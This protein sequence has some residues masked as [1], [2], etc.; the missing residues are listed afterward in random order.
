MATRS[1][2]QIEMMRFQEGRGNRPGGEECSKFLADTRSH[3]A[4]ESDRE[5]TGTTP[6][7][8]VPVQFSCVSCPCILLSTP[9]S[10]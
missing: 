9:Y 6:D 8:P 1:S 3:V 4:S 5:D 10:L 7:F 2:M